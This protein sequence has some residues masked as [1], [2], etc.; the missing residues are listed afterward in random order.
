M[1]AAIKLKLESELPHKL[2]GA[3]EE[4]LQSLSKFTASRGW[5]E[6]VIWRN[7]LASCKGIGTA[8]HFPVDKVEDSR[9]KLCKELATVS[10]HE[11]CTSDEVAVLYRS[12]PSSTV[13]AI[14]KAPTYERVEDR[15]TCVF[16]VFSNG[17]KAPLVTIGIA[18]RPRSFPRRF[19][20]MRDLGIFY[21]SQKKSWNIRGLW[22]VT[23]RGL[24]KT[25]QLQ[26]RKITAVLDNC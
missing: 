3:L 4:K 19:D 15:L 18:T 1:K 24:N 8:G 7:R 5:A 26:G 25:A 2:Q 10:I 16:T 13:R 22:Q 20:G 11:L 23:V 9:T 14:N 12:F 6:N 17:K 21:L